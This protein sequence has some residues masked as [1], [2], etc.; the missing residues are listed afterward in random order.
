M[1]KSKALTIRERD[2]P[3]QMFEAYDYEA[4]VATTLALSSFE[5]QRRKAGEDAI[6][7]A[8]RDAF[9]QGVEYAVS[10]GLTAAQWK[11]INSL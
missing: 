11:Q 5:D 10:R 4:H 6:R 1:P 3:T 8:V 2:K 7:S 9:D